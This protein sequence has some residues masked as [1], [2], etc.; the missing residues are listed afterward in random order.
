M[1]H[2]KTH[3]AETSCSMPCIRIIPVVFQADFLA[4]EMRR[5][6]VALLWDL[7]SGST[8]VE[9]PD[10]QIDNNKWHRIHATR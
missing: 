5:G 10:F 7:G 2:I 1:L 4:V 6:K 9:Y 3:K 8:R